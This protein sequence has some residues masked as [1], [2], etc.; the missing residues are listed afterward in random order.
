VPLFLFL[1]VYYF[2]LCIMIEELETLDETKSSRDGS[3]CECIGRRLVLHLSLQYPEWVFVF[4][5]DYLRK[6]NVE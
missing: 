2:F 4:G 1:I 6:K 5:N 3:A